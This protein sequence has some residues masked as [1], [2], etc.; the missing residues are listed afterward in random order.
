M[1]GLVCIW[2]SFPEGSYGG[3]WLTGAFVVVSLIAGAKLHVVAMHLS[4][5]AYSRFYRPVSS[6]KPSKQEIASISENTKDALKSDS[7]AAE[8]PVAEA[9]EQDVEPVKVDDS[10]VTVGEAP[11]K[12]V[13]LRRMVRGHSQRIK[14]ADHNEDLLSLFWFRKPRHMLRVFRCGRPHSCSVHEFVMQIHVPPEYALAPVTRR[15]RI[16]QAFNMSAR[17]VWTS[18]VE[19]LDAVVNESCSFWCNSVCRGCICACSQRT[20]SVHCG[21]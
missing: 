6:H 5:H 1:W 20:P 7:K 14:G 2:V 11:S 9:V 18:T 15:L 8:G 19:F 13:A 3:L 17:A 12:R 16:L 4:R 10:E 21:G